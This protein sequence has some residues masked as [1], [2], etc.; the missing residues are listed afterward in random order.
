M[1]SVADKGGIGNP[2]CGGAGNGY[3]AFMLPDEQTSPEQIAIFRRM[4]PEQRWHAAHRLYW[5]MRRH[6]A[7][8]LHSQHPEWPEERVAAEIREIFSH[9][10]T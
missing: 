1:S 2:A 5:T 10:R 6:K 3:I 9:A 4:T 7:A 8:F